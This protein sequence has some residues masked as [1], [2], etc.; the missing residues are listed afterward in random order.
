MKSRYVIDAG[1]LALY[2][3][4]DQ[5]VKKYFDN[6][7]YGKAEGYLCEINLAEFY[8]KTAEKLGIIPADLRYE[9]IRA[10]SIKQIPV[11]G[12]LTREAAK[13]KLRY[14]R[15]I[16]L[17]DVFLIALTYMVDGIALTTDSRIKEILKRKCRYFKI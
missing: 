14:R 8:Y 12:E 16:S 11:G 13:I 3:S 2:F 9:S 7:F 10:S 4:G 15:K 6:I 1:V 5:R 17:A